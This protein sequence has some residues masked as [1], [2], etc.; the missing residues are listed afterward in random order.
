MSQSPAASTS[1][2][3]STAPNVNL[4]TITPRHHRSEATSRRTTRSK[5]QA[6]KS[7]SSA[8]STSTQRRSE[9]TTPLPSGPTTRSKTQANALSG[10]PSNKRSTPEHDSDISSRKRAKTNFDQ[11]RTK[12]ETQDPLSL[13]CASYALELLSHGG[14]RSHVIAGSVE[15]QCIKLLYYDHSI[16]IESTPIDF[17][18]NHSMFI[19]LLS[20]LATLT[21]EQWGYHSIVDPP[22]RV[23]PP[24]SEQDAIVSLRTLEGQEIKLEGGKSLQLGKTVYHQ[25]GLIGRGTWVLRA[26]LRETGSDGGSDAIVKLSWSPTSRKSEHAM[27]NQA[28]G[29]AILYGDQWV[30]DHLPNVLHSQDFD[31]TKDG[32]VKGLI[33]LLGD[34]YEPRVLRL[35]VLEELFPITELAAASDLANAFRD[36]F[37]CECRRSSKETNLTSAYRL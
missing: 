13:Q 5:S 9:A 15:D 12:G 24:P 23:R 2:L 6:N 22:C 28:R 16:I 27:I 11:S 30:L 3:P 14:L 37:K 25:H 29:N 8:A 10:E 26:K 21:P 32:P 31:E 7:Q 20:G 18:T 1:T 34:K 4:R 19:A 36:I 17:M 35:L 33:E